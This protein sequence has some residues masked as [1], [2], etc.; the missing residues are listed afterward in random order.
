M[1]IEVGKFNTEGEAEIVRSFLEAG[2]IEARIESHTISSI[3]P[4]ASEFFGGFAVMVDD[5]DHEE[6]LRLLHSV[7]QPRELEY[8]DPIESEE[9]RARAHLKRAGNAAFIGTMFLPIVS[10]IYSF[11]HI[12]QACRF[13]GRVIMRRPLLVALML[14]FNFIGLVLFPLMFLAN[15]DLTKQILNLR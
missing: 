12:Y 3:M 15:P 13:S 9:D 5:A 14:I 1:S 8:K 7:N 2:G 6:A 11:Y 4:H 10:N